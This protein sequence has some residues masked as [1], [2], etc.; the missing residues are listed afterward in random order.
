[1]FKP[2]RQ[3]FVG[4]ELMSPKHFYRAAQECAPIR[5]SNIYGPTEN[6]TFS[7]CYELKEERRA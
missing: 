2:V 3:L 7:T 4:G 5:L 6:T 1:M